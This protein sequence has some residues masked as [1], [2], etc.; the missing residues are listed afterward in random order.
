M[1]RGF[2]LIEL[3]VVLVI[4]MILAMVGLG[5]YDAASAQPEDVPGEVVSL[6]HQAGSHAVSSGVTF[7]SNGRVR[8]VVMSSSTAERWLVVFRVPGDAGTA[9]TKAVRWA[10]LKVG[11]PITVRYFR[12]PLSGTVY[13]IEVP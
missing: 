6:E 10:S 13:G 4:L 8:P 12:G 3:A 5:A 11:D 7:G 1:R 9:R 2:T